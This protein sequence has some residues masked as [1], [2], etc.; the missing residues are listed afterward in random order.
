MNMLNT[1][2]SNIILLLLSTTAFSTPVQNNQTL[3]VN[4][5]LYLLENK[6]QVVDQHGNP[7]TDIDF[8]INTPEVSVFVGNG[9]LHYQ[10]TK[11][12]AP[13]VPT[14]PF[15]NKEKPANT[16]TE[17]Y[18][19]D[20][21]LLNANKN[22][23]PEAGD[24]Q[25]MYEN[26]YLPQCPA[27]ITANSYNKVVY[28]N[29][30]PNIDWVLYTKD[31]T[32]KYDFIVHKG[33][34][35]ADIKIKYNGA[36]SLK[37]KNGAL[38]ATTPFGTL[39]E[40]KPYSYEAITKKEIPSAYKLRN[41][42][43]SILLPFKDVETVIDPTIDWATYF[44][45]N[46]YENGL[47]ITADNLGYIYICGHTSSTTNIATT[48]AFQTSLSANSSGF[49]SKFSPSGAQI[50]GTYYGAQ[51][52]SR[53]GFS[54]I[55]VDIHN[56]IYAAGFTSD[57]G[58]ATPG[59]YQPTYGGGN[60][61]CI[62]VKFSDAGTRL[63]GSYYGGSGEESFTLSESKIACDTAGNL[64]LAGYTNSTS[65]IAT[66]GSHQPAFN[67][68][69]DAF[70][71][72]FDSTGSRLW[73]TYIGGANYEKTTGLCIDSKANIY[74][75]GE[76]DS[77]DSIATP[78]SYQ[79]A[80][81]NPI[82]FYNSFL[83]KFN[84]N[85]VRQWGTYISNDSSTY[86]L[87]VV[88]GKN[89]SV[90]ISG[91]T[92]GDTAIATPNA[93]QTKKLGATDGFAMRFND[94]GALQWGTYI[95]DTGYEYL[96]GL[97]VDANDN[98]YVSGHTSSLTGIATPDA[99][100]T[101]Y[102]SSNYSEDC[103]LIYN[104]LGQKMWGTYY[105]GTQHNN[106]YLPYSEVKHISGAGNS[107]TYLL[108]ETHNSTGIAT[109][110][111]HQTSIQGPTDVYIV[112]M[113]DDTSVFLTQ[114]YTDTSFCTG[115]T[116]TI[117]YDVLNNF[118]TGNTFTIQL[119]DTAGSFT[120]ATTIATINGNTGNTFKYIIPGAII[121]GIHYRMRVLASAPYDTS[122]YN[123]RSL[124]IGAAPSKPVA[125][126]HAP[127]CSGD[128]LK[129]YANSP[130]PG[131]Q[132]QWQG[133]GG[134]A[135][136]S[137]D[138]HRLNTQQV[139]SGDYIVSAD[140]LGCKSLDTIR[141]SVIQSPLPVVAIANTP[142]CVGDTIKLN[143]TGS[144][145]ISYTWTGVAGFTANT[146]DT[147][148][149]NA[150]TAQSG[151]YIVSATL[152]GCTRKDTI[153]ISVNTYPDTLAISGTPFVCEG[154]STILTATSTTPGITYNWTGPNS[155]NASSQ[156]A[157]LTGITSAATGNY[158]VTGTNILCSI[159]D[160]FALAVLTTP[161]ISSLSANTPVCIG[162]ALNLTATASNAT[163]YV[164]YG[165]GGYTSSTQN[166]TIASATAAVNGT[167]TVIAYNAACSSAAAT[168]NVTTAT[169]P[170]TNI[171]P[172]PGDSICSGSVI[173]FTAVPSAPGLSP[174]YQWYKN[175]IA[176]PSATTT[177]YTSNTTADK[178]IFYCTM[179]TTGVCADPYTDTSNHIPITVLPWLTPSVSIAATPNTPVNGGDM[180]TFAATPVNGGTKPVYQWKRNNADVI[181]AISNTWGS[182]NLA[183]ADTICVVMT[184]SYRCPSPATAKSNCIVVQINTTGIETTTLLNNIK[185]Y[186]NPVTDAI[187]IEGIQTA[188]TI[189]LF[190]VTGRLV[191]NTTAQQSIATIGTHTLAVGTY[192]LQL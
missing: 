82:Q 50:W 36:T 190:D 130:S 47:K 188:T 180:I 14:L 21:E 60:F 6:G 9:Q 68:I 167:Y 97:D 43:L 55:A 174:Q 15:V 145:A 3:P 27:G 85:G 127:L 153:L 31:N 166:P 162:R 10:W 113:T 117:R 115:D 110:G 134:F 59:S 5:K 2:F 90:F 35:P 73:G 173:K 186:P 100:K 33:G 34:N 187:H 45:G 70:L 161:V 78:G 114:P 168:V 89:N 178:D 171:Y 177:S 170:V 103:L 102:T 112:K 142:L 156:S 84:N 46:Q 181:G 118:R 146:R 144:N 140:V 143:A 12:D 136:F 150:N 29:V 123:G 137:K 135:S 141:V 154:A 39:T 22:A 95:G 128:S 163:G 77:P 182:P 69:S 119:S 32:L 157:T 185:I 24:A 4:N 132:W 116:M 57:T 76:T 108:G 48:G 192:I 18:R 138:T 179:T 74:V 54:S 175:N 56:R 126:Y 51:L 44:G 13:A 93:W 151:N 38:I 189:Q 164:W 158:I 71:V 131:I 152:N 52:F 122:V 139:D 176:I 37:L 96:W 41:N 79:G 42:I 133:P 99:V 30:Y 92:Y 125:S 16:T 53:T 88:A 106:V 120:S 28:R 61:D 25:P 155:F 107:A 49:L 86:V 7:R 101:S 83:V 98:I 165:P 23:V 67:A 72:K 20:I 64:F 184:S 105:G 40:E 160:T 91:T 63:W 65:G 66:A 121:P 147:F 8:K 87:N 109:A 148:I 81:F 11:T 80:R 129:L 58:L 169:G 124:V 75:V 1:A 19:L 26:Y 183:N 111:A 17:I 149:A 94:S 159:T 62:V 172:S 191:I 104:G